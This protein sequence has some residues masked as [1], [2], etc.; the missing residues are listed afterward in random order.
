MVP[1]PARLTMPTKLRD[2]EIAAIYQAIERHKGNKHRAAEELG[3]STKTLYNKLASEQEK[4]AD[5]AA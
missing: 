2:L 3:I 1:P 5:P 4:Q